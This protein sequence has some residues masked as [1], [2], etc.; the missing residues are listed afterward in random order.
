ML[1]LDRIMTRAGDGGVTRLADGTALPKQHPLLEA[2]GAIDE[3]NAIF[4][5]CRAQGPPAP[6]DACLAAV[7]HDLFD[8]GADLAQPAARPALRL[9]PVQVQRLEA[10]IAE[11]TARLPPLASFV[12]PGGT[13][14]AASLHLA[15]TVVRRAERALCAAIAAEPARSWNPCLVPYVNRL[16]DACFVWAR[17]I[18]AASGA[19]TLWQPGC[20]QRAGMEAPPPPPS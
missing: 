12:L 16:S 3:A 17:L 1:R 15:R 14:L 10:W 2:L 18:N 19:E 11:G 7:Q 8:L 13:M 20:G 4:G 9:S 6:L 5:L